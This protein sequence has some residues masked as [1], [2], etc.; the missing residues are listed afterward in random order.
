MEHS[1]SLCFSQV[2]LQVPTGTRLIPPENC[3]E[4]IKTLMQAC[5]QQNPE[6]R[7]DF[8]YILSELEKVQTDHNFTNLS[9]GMLDNNES[10][11]VPISAKTTT[12]YIEIVPGS[13][14]PSPNTF[15]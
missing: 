2:L 3:P 6:E 12:S 9:Y 7:P 11:E 14:D 10:Y 4:T 15:Q 13:R 5:W 1:V 8:S